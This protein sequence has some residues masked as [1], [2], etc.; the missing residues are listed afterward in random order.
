M[1]EKIVQVLLYF[2][3]LRNQL[4]GCFDFE[5][6]NRSVVGEVETGEINQLDDFQ[7]MD[8][9]VL[10]HTEEVQLILVM[11]MEGLKN[12]GMWQMICYYFGVIVVVV[13][14]AYRLVVELELER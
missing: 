9:M 2:H 4:E 5:T 10:L 13:A 8:S 14:S 3:V 7:K 12:H 11:I 1:R 6:K